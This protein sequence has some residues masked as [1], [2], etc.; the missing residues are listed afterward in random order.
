MN[1]II[2]W[3]VN[4]FYARLNHIKLLTAEQNPVALCFQETNCK[5]NIYPN[6]RGFSTYFKNRASGGV[7]ILVRSDFHSEQ[8][9]INTDLEVVAINLWCPQKITICNI[10]IP[11][12]KEL[13]FREIHH[14]IKQLQSPYLITGDFNA[15][16]PYGAPRQ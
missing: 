2:Q 11:L 10:Y 1:N 13:L 4:G 15:H 5:D 14:I 16:S 12:N 9:Q 7:A 6:I 3:N 8:L